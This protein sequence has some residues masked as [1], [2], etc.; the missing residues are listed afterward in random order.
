MVQPATACE[1]LSTLGQGPGWAGEKPSSG[2]RSTFRFVPSGGV[3]THTQQG[4]CGDRGPE[5]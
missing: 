5:P 1:P 3:A 2:L 4:S